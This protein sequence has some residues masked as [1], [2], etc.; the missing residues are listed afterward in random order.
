MRSVLIFAHVPPPHHGQSYMVAQLIEELRARP[1]EIR[2]FHVDNRVSA[3]LEDV[4]AKG[5]GKVWRTLRYCLQAIR[6]RLRHG[7]MVFYYVPA[8]AKRGALYRDWLVMGLCRPFFRGRLVL[9]WH[10]VGLGAWLAGGAGRFTAWVTRRLLG[11][12]ALS[13]VLAQV[14]AEDAEVLRPRQIRV[15]A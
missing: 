13:L 9:H 15:L 1:D 6:L 11:G 14:V 5:I 8:P 10:A 12:A 7:P 3:R 2:V 4:G